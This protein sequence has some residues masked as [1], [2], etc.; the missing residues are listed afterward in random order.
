MPTR[1]EAIKAENDAL[2]DI[3]AC[4]EAGA[5]LQRLSDYLG[6]GADRDYQP[7]K[8]LMVVIRSLH[9]IKTRAKARR[10]EASKGI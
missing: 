4:S 10:K 7:T 3:A 2:D 8:D 6:G 5:A 9:A 1:N